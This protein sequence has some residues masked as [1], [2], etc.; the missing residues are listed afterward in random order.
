MF[1]VLSDPDCSGQILESHNNNIASESI[2]LD[3]LPNP[4]KFIVPVSYVN[5]SLLSDFP[6]TVY[7]KTLTGIT[8]RGS[9]IIARIAIF[10]VNS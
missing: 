3:G 10:L 8:Q 9:T 5:H 4:Y 1:L 7:R 6:V 2:E